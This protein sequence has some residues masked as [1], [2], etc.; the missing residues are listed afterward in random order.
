MKSDDSARQ[1]ALDPDT[2]QA[3][4]DWKTIQDA[5]RK[6]F[7]ADYQDTDR[8]FAWEGGRAGPP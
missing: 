1:N 8:V 6:F 4:R 7:G 3:L 5:E 2:V